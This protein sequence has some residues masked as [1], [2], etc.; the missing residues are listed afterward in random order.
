MNQLSLIL[1]LPSRLLKLRESLALKRKGLLTTHDII[2]PEPFPQSFQRPKLLLPAHPR[3]LWHKNIFPAINCQRLDIAET[4]QHPQMMRLHDLVSFERTV[5]TAQ[6]A[7]LSNTTAVA[8]WLVWR[9]FQDLG[10][11]EAQAKFLDIG[12]P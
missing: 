11:L 5:P 9:R 10:V 6:T 3:R 12:A 2:L 7:G 1:L 4:K 8:A